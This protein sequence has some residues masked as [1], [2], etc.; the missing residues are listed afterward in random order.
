[1]EPAPAQAAFAWPISDRA[2]HYASRQNQRLPAR[3]TAGQHRTGTRATL[4]RTGP[5][6]AQ[7]SP[8]NIH[9]VIRQWLEHAIDLLR[10]SAGQTT[11]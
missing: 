5:I 3:F 10:N 1:M 8:M 11:A 6:H 2:R 4:P 7:D 9:P